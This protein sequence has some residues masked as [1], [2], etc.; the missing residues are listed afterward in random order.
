MRMSLKLELP[1][2]ERPDKNSLYISDPCCM[3]D[4]NIFELEYI[5]AVINKCHK[6][7]NFTS[8]N[9]KTAKS[10]LNIVVF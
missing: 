8:F 5:K 4:D 7:P 1:D 3:A 2:E 10:S 6:R 9:E